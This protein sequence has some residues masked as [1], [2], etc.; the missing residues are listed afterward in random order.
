MAGLLDFLGLGKD[1]KDAA[2]GV[3]GGVTKIIDSAKGQVPAD[4]LVAMEQAKGQI[5]TQ[6]AT[7]TA[8][9][10]AAFEQFML[11]YEGTAAQV[12]PWILTLRAMIRPVT[13]IVFLAQLAVAATYDFTLLA[14]G[15]I[16]T[17]GMI[18]S[19]LPSGY[20]VIQG[21]IVGFWFGGKA[22][23]RIAEAFGKASKS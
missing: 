16:T 14:L 15:K 10:D 3:L 1:V 21:I 9:T 20:W 6:L 11:Q 12:K 2:D 17:D 18:L 5:Q 8:N 7:I 22:G 23:E 13:T 4:Q 19:H